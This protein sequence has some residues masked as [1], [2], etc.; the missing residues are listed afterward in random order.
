MRES[1]LANLGIVYFVD[2]IDNRDRI[3]NR[4]GNLFFGVFLKKVVDDVE[5]GESES[6]SKRSEG[7]TN[8]KTNVV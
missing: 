7:R 5:I 2:D 6:K 3:D 4:S 8:E 1:K